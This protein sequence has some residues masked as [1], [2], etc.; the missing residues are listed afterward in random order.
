MISVDI[1]I[2]NK[3]IYSINV[4]NESIKK[5]IRENNIKNPDSKLSFRSDGRIEWICEHGIGHTIFSENNNFVHGCDGCCSKI[6]FKFKQ[7]DGKMMY[8]T[9]PG[10]KII[11]HK[12]SDGAIILSQKMLKTLEKEITTD[13]EHKFSLEN[14]LKTLNVKESFYD[15]S[16]RESIEEN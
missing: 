2:N 4:V 8:L 11:W 7:K 13:A 1:K 15:K 9:K 3:V 12:R 14:I 5:F 6:K 10:N 16:F